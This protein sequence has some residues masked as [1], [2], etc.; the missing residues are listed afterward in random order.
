MSECLLLIECHDVR[1]SGSPKQ[2]KRLLQ[3]IG[4]REMCR[5]F[6]VQRADTL[7]QSLY[8]RSEKL[9]SIETARAQLDEIIANEKCFSLKQLEISGGDL[10]E[11]G[12]PKGE[13]IG[14]ILNTL[15]DE[16]IDEKIPNQKDALIKRAKEL[17][18]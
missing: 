10:I 11:I 2:I 14:K 13:R 7:A 16:V 12:I 6:K 15:L 1:Y 5:L 4:E 9:G 8:L 17:A 3:K 18:E